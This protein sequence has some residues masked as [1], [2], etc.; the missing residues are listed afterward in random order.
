MV[1]LYEILGI[2]GILLVFF[3]LGIRLL[4]NLG[5]EGELA[6]LLVGL[7]LLVVAYV[8]QSRAD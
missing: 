8:M 2:L 4:F 1:K 6:I 5:P 7:V 3:G